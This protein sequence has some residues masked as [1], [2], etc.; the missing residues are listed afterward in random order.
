MHLENGLDGDE[1]EYEDA[2]RHCQSTRARALAHHVYARHLINLRNISA[3]AVSLKM[4]NHASF[5]SVT[6]CAYFK[7]RTFLFKTVEIFVIGKLGT[8]GT[9]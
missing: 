3:A 5:E 6:V 1:H 4:Q 2:L 8:S 9:C 7:Y